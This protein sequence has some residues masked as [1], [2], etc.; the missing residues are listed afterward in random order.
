MQGAEAPL[1]LSR[2]D[3]FALQAILGI[4]A[5]T[6]LERQGDQRLEIFLSR[7]VEWVME[8]GWGQVGVP[9]AVEGFGFRLLVAKMAGRHLPLPP[10]AEHVDFLIDDCDDFIS[11]FCGGTEEELEE[12]FGWALLVAILF[13]CGAADASPSLFISTQT[14]FRLRSRSEALERGILQRIARHAGVRLKGTSGAFSL[15]RVH[16]RLR[17][18]AG[19]VAA[20]AGLRLCTHQRHIR[21]LRLATAVT[22]LAPRVPPG[23]LDP[24]PTPTV[25]TGAF[26]PVRARSLALPCMQEARRWLDSPLIILHRGLATS[27]GCSIARAGMHPFNFPQ[28]GKASSGIST[29]LGSCPLSPPSTW[30]GWGPGVGATRCPSL[31]DRAPPGKSDCGGPLARLP[32]HLARPAV[33]GF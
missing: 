4:G 20:G 14:A 33:H 1:V 18:L 5:S 3:R 24:T 22:W 28:L 25:S 27:P 7:G 10:L 32:L 31:V 19:Q 2:S 6:L 9:D 21:C 12:A 29:S 8:N 11:P 26:L 13:H 23:A 17:D 30:L 16:A 15:A